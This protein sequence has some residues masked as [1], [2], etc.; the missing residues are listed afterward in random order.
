MVRAGLEEA[1]PAGPGE[2]DEN[3]FAGRRCS[4]QRAWPGQRFRGQIPD[5]EPGDIRLVCL[6]QSGLRARP[7]VSWGPALAPGIFLEHQQ[8]G[9]S[10]GGWGGCRE[11][12]GNSAHP[13]WDSACLIKAAVA[14]GAEPAGRGGHGEGARP[15]APG[16]VP[17]P[18]PALGT[19]LTQ[20]EEPYLAPV[21]PPA[22]QS[23]PWGHGRRGLAP[24][25]PSAPHPSGC[26]QVP[27]P[28]HA[29]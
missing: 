22:A 27:G 21:P 13:A 7:R 5:P 25:P 12:P 17:L 29:F 23:P 8:P 15:P 9:P 1:R 16:T 24:R 26:C 14:A 20:P 2:K 28:P 19:A 10:A 4:E 18:V 3:F 6:G 11:A